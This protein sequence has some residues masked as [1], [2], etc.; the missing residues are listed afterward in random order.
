MKPNLGAL[1]VLVVLVPAYFP[2]S[3]SAQ[4][5][6]YLLDLTDARGVIGETATI[7][8]TVTSLA[9]EL[10]AYQFDVCD[11][12]LIETGFG[13]VELGLTGGML[14]F[15]SHVVDFED[16]A[17]SVAAVLDTGSAVPTDEP[18]EL[19]LVTYDLLEEGVSEPNFCGSLLPPLLTTVG[20]EEIEPTTA[21][22]SIS[23]GTTPPGVAF[24]RGDSNGDGLV[25]PLE[26][27][28]VLMRYLFVGTAVPACLDAADAD[29]NGVLSI[30]DAV[31]VL[32]WGFLGGAAPDDPGP[33]T[34]GVDPEGGDLGCDAPPTPCPG[35]PPLL[36]PDPTLTLTVSLPVD[37]VPVE[38]VV[39]LSI[40]LGI[41]GDPMQGYQFGV[42][43]GDGLVLAD[44]G[45]ASPIAA[46]ADLP[47]DD[48]IFVAEL[49]LDGGWTAVGYWNPIFGGELGAGEYEIYLAT[50]TV[51]VE[52]F[53]PVEFCEGLGD[54]VVPARI[55]RGGDFLLPTTESGGV[56]GSP[57]L[58]DFD[59]RL[60][61][62][63]GPAGGAAAITASVT[64]DG[65][66][67]EGWHWGVCHDGP[68]DIESGDILGGLA[69][70]GLAFEFETISVEADGWTVDALLVAGAGLDPGDDLELYVATYSLEADGAATLSFCD[71]L[72][73]PSVP[74]GWVVSGAEFEP[75][76]FDGSIV[77]G[78]GIVF[79]FAVNAPIVDYDP[80]DTGGGV[81]FSVGLTIEEA[82]A[83]LGFPNDTQAFSMGIGHDGA[84][85]TAVD[86]DPTTLLTDLN[87]GAGPDFIGID[88]TPAD[89]ADFGVTLGVAYS[90]T[91]PVFLQFD[92]ALEVIEVDY[93]VVD[94]NV[95][96]GD[97]DG[98]T[99]SLEWSEELG[100]PDV[101]NVVT[102]DGTTYVPFL[103]DGEVMFLPETLPRFRRGDIDGNGA[104]STLLDA[105]FMLTWAFAQGDDPPCMDA[106]DTD[107]SGGVSALLDALFLLE[108]GFLKG[109]EPPAPGPITCGTDPEGDTDGTT[110]DSSS[111]G[112]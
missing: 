86:A 101:V 73:D 28:D 43:H 1:R 98:L 39:T 81:T 29:N 77:I 58:P 76:T 11:D 70:S 24:L 25:Q 112:C 82:T 26:D 108:W 62:A 67:L 110:C 92:G 49:V 59:L 78:T 66:P 53:T 63:T 84:L 55:L 80:T 21:S 20:A 37:S 61:S 19:Y 46:G 18:F 106:A 30:A 89:G 60:S 36:D 79:R 9:D 91:A 38:E 74:V 93:E 105:L 31:V 8:V 2:A 50:Y 23:I 88:V 13:G 96:A 111:D 69:T 6:D 3:V 10:S 64:N 94:T 44:L 5:P 57:D 17:W 34:C 56:T 22:G 107:N 103:V 100:T 54:P 4:D 51:T 65:D 45:G 99:T 35:D 72:G 14:D 52:G 75:T 85:L 97:V 33:T 104:V 32:V 41:D 15:S 83:S 102:V 90:F 40:T 47:S 12:A 71:T 42:C 27:V 95:L 16:D 87:G 48:L 68:V 109:D 7:G